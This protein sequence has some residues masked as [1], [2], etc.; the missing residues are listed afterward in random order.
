MFNEPLLHVFHVA[1][2]EAGPTN[3]L[4]GLFPDQS[5]GGTLGQFATEVNTVACAM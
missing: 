3:D 5:G 1:S 4:A 2:T